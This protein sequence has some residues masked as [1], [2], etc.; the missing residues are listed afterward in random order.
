MNRGGLGTSALNV[1]LQKQLNGDAEP[2]ITRFGTTFAPGD[3]VIQLVNNYDKDVFNGDIGFISQ[4]NLLDATLT[5]HFDQR[6]VSYDFSELDEISLAYAI[7]IHKSQG[8]EFPIIV[9]P[10]STQHYVLLAKNL[11]Y[12]GVTRGKRLVVLVGQKRAV[13]MA[14]NNTQS[15]ARLTNLRTRLA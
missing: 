12:T 1:T 11:L 13:W 3:K 10:I 4:I 7:S 6:A 9:L 2:T 15:A 5:I 14:I 8:S